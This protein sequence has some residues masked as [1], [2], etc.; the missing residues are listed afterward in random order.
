MEIYLL[1][2]LNRKIFVIDKDYLLYSDI[3]FSITN[4]SYLNTLLGMAQIFQ[5]L[6]N[7]KLL[8]FVKF[9]HPWFALLQSVVWIPH[10]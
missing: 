5:H 2:Y 3:K 9:Y 6:P 7:S 1:Q 8:S 4:L 10:L